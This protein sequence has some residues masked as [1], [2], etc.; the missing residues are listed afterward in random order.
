MTALVIVL[1]VLVA[2]LSLL[3][4]GLLRSHATIL[5]R[6]HELDGGEAAAGATSGTGRTSDT[7]QPDFRAMPGIP[8]PPGAVALPYPSRPDQAG[9]PDVVGRGLADESIVVR[10]GGVDQ[11]T[12]LA[13]LSSS[14]TTCL[15]FW[16]DFARPGG[17]ALPPATRLV[18]VTKDSD[19][20]SP[21][22]IDE[23]KPPGVEVVM[24]SRAWTDLG[25]PGSPYVVAVDGPSG[26]V[27]GEGTGMA[28]DQVARLLVQAT[29]DTAFM[30]GSRAA[31][32]ASDADREARVDREL[33]AAGILP[34][35][36]SLYATDDFAETPTDRYAADAHAG[37]I[38]GSR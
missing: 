22:L 6:L 18:I 11:N 27:I 16:D 23:L 28:W 34:G 7:G 4:G 20:E 33:L 15:A 32:P 17:V 3:V 30:T 8:A 19:E 36:P 9:A 2:A 24:S 38:G 29:G 21:V 12:V 13:F 14:C 31:K 1:T 10:L 26:R 35:D 25:V 5:R 37:D